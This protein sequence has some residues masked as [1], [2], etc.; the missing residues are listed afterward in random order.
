MVK[1]SGVMILFGAVIYLAGIYIGMLV[2]LPLCMFLHGERS[3][4]IMAGITAFILLFIFLVF[5]VGLKVPRPWGFWAIISVERGL[6]NMDAF[7]QALAA[8]FAPAALFYTFLGVLFGI[9][10]GAMPGLSAVMASSIMLPFTFSLKDT[11]IMMLLGI[12]CGAIYGGS[13]TAILINTP[14]T[15]NSAAHLPGRISHGP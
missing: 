12:F 13:I 3:G 7:M 2:M 15:A 9:L 1:I 11:G 14:G 5:D 10:C 6:T 4:K 8:V